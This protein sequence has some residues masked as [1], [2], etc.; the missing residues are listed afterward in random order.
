[1]AQHSSDEEGK[2]VEKKMPVTVPS[3]AAVLAPEVDLKET[4]EAAA[5][6]VEMQ[7]GRCGYR[8]WAHK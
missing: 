4:A 6:F 8:P 7:C 2:H 3:T 5:A 1:M